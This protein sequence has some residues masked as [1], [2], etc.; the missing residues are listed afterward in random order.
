MSKNYY[1][2]KGRRFYILLIILYNAY[3]IFLLLDPKP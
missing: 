2:L 1:L 3:I